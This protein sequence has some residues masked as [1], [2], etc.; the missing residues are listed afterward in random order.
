MA[1]PGLADI[2][3]LGALPDIPHLYATN[4]ALS[5]IVDAILLS[6]VFG[7]ILAPLMKEILKDEKGRRVGAVIGLVLGLSSAFALRTAG[8]TLFTYWLTTVITAALIAGFL[9]RIVDK[10][11]GGKLRIITIPLAILLAWMIMDFWFVTTGA[12]LVR[13]VFGFVSLLGPFIFVIFLAFLL[14]RLLPRRPPRPPGP[15][16]PPGP[17]RPPRGPGIL[18]RLKSLVTPKRIK[19]VRP[20]SVRQ[21]GTAAQKI[22]DDA[23]KAVADATKTT[24]QVEDTA[25]KAEDEIIMIEDETKKL[26]LPSQKEAFLKT[27]KDVLS[28]VEALA[29]SARN[30]KGQIS[31]LLN[32]KPR[33]EEYIRKHNRL[34]EE[35]AKI[36]FD[37]IKARVEEL[38]K[39]RPVTDLERKFEELQNNKKTL[40]DSLSALENI[41]N[42]LQQHLQFVQDQQLRQLQEYISSLI[43]NI[44]KYVPAAQRI[45]NKMAENLARET[46][47]RA[48][49]DVQGYYL[50]R[51]Q[52][53]LEK[54][55]TAWKDVQNRAGYSRSAI[56]AVNA[57]LKAW[58]ETYTSLVETTMRT[59]TSST[60]ALEEAL[61][62]EEEAVKAQKELREKGIPEL[63]TILERI[64]TEKA[65]IS[66]LI[67]QTKN[68]I[69]A[70]D[71]ESFE[72]KASEKQIES[73]AR[74]AIK[75]AK[76]ETG[77]EKT[78]ERAVKKTLRTVHQALEHV[79]ALRKITPPG[80]E[81]T[82]L[83]HLEHNLTAFET[84]QTQL[85]DWLA[86]EEK[87]LLASVVVAVQESKAKKY[88]TARTVKNKL[89]K[90]VEDLEK[91][92]Q[93]LSAEAAQVEKS[94]RRK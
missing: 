1:R 43:T 48:V 47:E 44:L 76:K 84:Y 67:G 66:A 63:A 83:E 80:P 8:V 72:K 90:L 73:Q 41:K 62:A 29:R 82:Q 31:R 16:S 49:R 26:P 68:L 2:P 79:K 70:L 10:L 27:I 3:I 11:L 21:T 56:S 74:K 15:P 33:I 91:A 89:V 6:A 14:A 54:L 17:P 57:D 87:T 28:R 23:R 55:R 37:N 42:R 64:Q 81:A 13:N 38:K 22:A 65:V 51:L 35:A 60:N 7:G 12:R 94:V 46:Y 52:N 30:L 93:Y 24:K 77:F 20:E 58:Q 34:M 39:T 25:K 88:V 59:I 36:S 69:N 40:D 4:P 45:A 18:S 53:D 61:R 32:L 86:K 78:E 19:V 5:F 50:P 75:A 71:F 85:L 9:Y 92:L